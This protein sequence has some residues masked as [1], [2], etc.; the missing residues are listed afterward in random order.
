MMEATGAERTMTPAV[1]S[2]RAVFLAWERLCVVYN[3]VLVVV[4]L[5]FGGSYLGDGAFWWFLAYYAVIANLCYCLGPVIEG[6]FGLLGADRRLVR[7]SVFV[8]GTLF[9]SL[10]ASLAV[11]FWHLHGVD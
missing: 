3:A 2:A 9:G 7:W 10:L 4:V 5:I 1:E 6:Y 8:L 11:S